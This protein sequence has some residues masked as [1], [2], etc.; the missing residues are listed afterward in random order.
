MLWAESSANAWEEINRTFLYLL[1]ATL[2]FV[3][4]RWAGP[5]ALRLLALCSWPLSL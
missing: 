4:V 1:G 3:A 5:V 2:V